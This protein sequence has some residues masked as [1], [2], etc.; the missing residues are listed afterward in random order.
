MN[1]DFE[2]LQ[3]YV[4]KK[5]IKKATASKNR[6]AEKISALRLFIRSPPFILL[7]L[8]PQLYSADERGSYRRSLHLWQQRR[9]A[10]GTMQ[11]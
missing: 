2:L 11:E 8:F 6:P 1:I 4:Y 10:P 3:F 9:Q 5:I 7:C